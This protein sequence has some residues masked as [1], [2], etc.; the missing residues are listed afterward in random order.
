MSSRKADTEGIDEALLLDSIGRR[1]QDG[2]VQP[3]E[4]RDA[5]ALKAEEAPP[6]ATEAPKEG[7]RRKRQSVDYTA[8]FLKRN[9]IK[10][11]QCVYISREIHTKISKIVNIL[12]AEKGI[13][14]GGYIDTV[15]AQHLKEHREAINTLYKKQLNNLI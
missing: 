7:G 14:I 11:R 3:Q 12:A 9:E 10:T 5:S 6:A 4:T 15:L 1:K 13:S 8:T 2:S